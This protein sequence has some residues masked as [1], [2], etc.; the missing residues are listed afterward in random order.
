MDDYISKP[1]QIQELM[2]ILKKHFS[3]ATHTNTYASSLD[4]ATTS[5]QVLDRSALKVLEDTLAEEAG[6]L[7]SELIDT[8]LMDTPNR[9]DKLQL[10]L[11]QNDTKNARNL[12]HTLKSSSAVLGLNQFS[13]LCEALEIAGKQENIAEMPQIFSQI[14]SH[15]KNVK[16]ALRDLQTD[17][18]KEQN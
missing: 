7:I 15:F 11:D 2:A 4:I 9:L 8:Y 6:L 16:T 10:A 5:E 18:S 1:I 17:L 14:T 3:Q 12:A 13:N